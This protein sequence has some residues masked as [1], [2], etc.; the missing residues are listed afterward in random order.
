[1][2][3]TK[4]IYKIEKL[5]LP[6]KHKLLKATTTFNELEVMECFTIPKGASVKGSISGVITYAKKH[7]KLATSRTNPDGSATIWRLR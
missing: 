5:P 2:T 6:H 7:N 1:M 4:D 3:N